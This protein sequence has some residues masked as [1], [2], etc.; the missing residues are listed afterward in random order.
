MTFEQWLKEIYLKSNGK[1][2]SASSVEKY[3]RGLSITSEDMLEKG[4]I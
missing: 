4:V 3:K 1:S 2:L